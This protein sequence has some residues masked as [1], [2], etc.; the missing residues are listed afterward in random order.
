MEQFFSQLYI[1]L[2]KQHYL[3]I[4]KRQLYIISDSSTLF[5]KLKSALIYFAYIRLERANKRL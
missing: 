3:A 4:I 1:Y 5:S 2:K